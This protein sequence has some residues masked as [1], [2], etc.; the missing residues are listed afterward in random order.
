M[1]KLEELTREEL[2]TVIC[3]KII[4]LTDE[5]EENVTEDN[6]EDVCTLISAMSNFADRL[7]S[8]LY[9]DAVSRAYDCCCADR[10]DG[11]F[12]KDTGLSAEELI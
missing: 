3:L 12:A 5:D 8:E 2:M 7:D 6:Y 1:K 4:M 11:E 9:K 10:S